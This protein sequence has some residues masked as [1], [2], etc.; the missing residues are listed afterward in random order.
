MK[1]L[2]SQGRRVSLDINIQVLANMIDRGAE[3]I[4]GGETTEFCFNYARDCDVPFI[5]I[6]HALTEEPGL[7]IA[8]GDI[9][10][11]F[12]ALKVLFYSLGKPWF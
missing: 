2:G 7:E 6:S 11:R 5:E 1:K 3:A 10:K 4:V 8:A 9:Q 12:P